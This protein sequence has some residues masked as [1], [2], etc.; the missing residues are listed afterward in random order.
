MAGYIFV[1]P[2]ACLHLYM[3]PRH[4]TN[5]IKNHWEGAGLGGKKGEWHKGSSCAIG[6]GKNGWSIR[7]G[8]VLEEKRRRD[9]SPI[10]ETR[11]EGEGMKSL[12]ECKDEYQGRESA[13]EISEG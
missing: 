9:V 2:Y 6:K 1:C 4:Q 8:D 7:E 5:R 3:L 13:R 12:R 10:W 11:N